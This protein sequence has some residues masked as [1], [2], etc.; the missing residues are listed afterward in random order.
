MCA[1]ARRGLWDWRG[2]VF[3]AIVCGALSPAVSAPAAEKELRLPA[4]QRAAEFLRK[5]KS[6]K[7]AIG[8]NSALGASRALVRMGT[9]VLSV[10]RPGHL[11]L[12]EPMFNK[13]TLVADGQR[14]S[15]GVGALKKYAVSERPAALEDV[16]YEPEAGMMLNGTG[17]PFFRGL[18]AD[19]PYEAW[20]YDISEIISVQGESLDGRPCEHVHVKVQGAFNSEWHIWVDANEKPLISKVSIEQGGNDDGDKEKASFKTLLAYRFHDWDFAPSFAD[21]EFTFTAPTDWEKVESIFPQFTPRDFAN[22][23]GSLTKVGDAAPDIRIAPLEGEELSLADLRGRVVLINFF[24][25][26]C[27]PC[28]VEMPDLEKIWNEFGKHD[29]FRMYG[30]AREET[31]EIVREFNDKQHFTFPLAADPDRTAFA[32]FA[33]ESIP[34]TY[35]IDREGRIIYQCTGYD[36]EKRERKKLR[37]LLKQELAKQP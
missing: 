30:I 8:H 1:I 21:D 14:L 35:L 5:Q 34:R 22:R 20:M 36:A 19:D 13:I 33:E 18:L 27:G 9:A 37:A 25:T 32:S 3:A 2:G 11:A 28:R 10:S 6:F 26:W 31:P 12:R 24:A 29:Q 4:L 15:R 17:S 7:V 16:F 23:P